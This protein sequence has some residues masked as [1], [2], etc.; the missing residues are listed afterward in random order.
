MENKIN[1]IA[2]DVDNKE[3]YAADLD[4]ALAVAGNL[5]ILINL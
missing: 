1:T 3:Q 5:F 4:Q 2:E